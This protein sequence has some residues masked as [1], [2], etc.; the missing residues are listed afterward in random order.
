[1]LINNINFCVDA[2]NDFGQKAEEST[3]SEDSQYQYNSM[4]NSNETM[5]NDILNILL[6]ILDEKHFSTSRQQD[7]V[8]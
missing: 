8:R 5:R 6:Q 3:E 7:F 1:M 2:R 4:F